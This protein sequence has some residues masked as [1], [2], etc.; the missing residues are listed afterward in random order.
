MSE[1]IPTLRSY[2]QILI[3]EIRKGCAGKAIRAFCWSK[4]WKRFD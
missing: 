4:H 2:V 3:L 1:L